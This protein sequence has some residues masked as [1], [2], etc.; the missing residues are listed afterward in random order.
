MK[1][2]AII[3]SGFGGLSLGIRLQAKGWQVKIFEKNSQPGGH[4]NQLLKKGYKFDMGPSL[5]T[6]PDIL[7]NV[8][9]SA[10]KN[11]EDYLDL[12]LLDPYYRI[13]FHDK[14][15]IDYSGDEEF[16]KAQMA[17]FN[18]GD[19]GKYDKFIE[20]SRKIYEAVIKEGLGST[21]FNKPSVMAKFVPKAMSM[22]A[23][24]SS[25]GLA[26]KYFSDFRH[27][28]MFSFHPLFIGGNPFRVPAIYLMISYLEKEG[29]VWFTKGG[30]KSLVDAFV[31]V[32]SELGGEISL[33]SEVREIK[34]DNGKAKGIITD[35]E[36]YDCD[37]VIS[38]ADVTHTY[39]K[40]I[41]GD[42]SKRWSK[43]K[44][45]KSKFSMGAFLLYLGVRKKYPELLHH[46][47]ILS[48]RYKPLIDDIFDNKILPDDFSMYLHVPTRS[49]ESMAP[50][51]CE[52]I[53]VLVPVANLQSG[54]NWDEKARP[55]ANTII[56]FLEA[57]FN[58]VGLRENIEVEE[59]F[60]PKDFMEQRNSHMGTPWGMEPVLAQT[61]YFRPHNKSEDIENLYLVGA[62]THPGGGLPGVMLSA[63]A[64]E[65][66]IVE[67]NV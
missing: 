58:M 3:G 14:S 62:G 54:I 40:L 8:F 21:P 4:A 46:T 15:Y 6:A 56:N 17:V 65:K 42:A 31:K 29:G 33:D 24:Y 27:R 45:E 44:L 13:Y 11:I 41:K 36:D 10:G 61:A 67:D 19:A 53:Y 47:L 16:M 37:I 49:D 43:Q 66:L 32:F 7:G 34:L 23:F 18:K 48:P 39:S 1:K 25:Y 30:M 64:T 12:L 60:T 52:S 20:N 5:I 57:D 51:G 59:I 22:K 55:F 28:F 63:E 26:S 50:E 2:A 38:N 9:K 35:K